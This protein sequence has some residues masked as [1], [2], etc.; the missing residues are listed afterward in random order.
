MAR[1]WNV[2]SWFATTVLALG[3]CS[4]DGSSPDPLPG[5]PYLAIVARLDV[6]D[7]VSAGAR[8][9]FH[10]EELSGTLGIDTVFQV[11]PQDTIILSVPPATYRVQMDGLPSNCI[12]RYG[13]EQLLLVPEGSNTTL[14]RYYV[15]CR[16]PLVVQVYT[17]GAA[18][19]DRYYVRATGDSI[20]ERLLLAA[21]NDTLVLDSIPGGAEIQLE[22]GALSP[23]C[24]ITTDGRATQRVTV[25]PAG[26]TIVTFRVRCSEE[27]RRPRISAFVS[28]AVDGG[29]VL[30]FRAADPDRDIERYTFDL[31]DCQGRSVLPNGARLR[32]GLSSGRTAR[33]DSVIVVGA[34]ELPLTAAEQAGRCAELRV[35]D[36]SGNTSEWT[37]VTASG[38]GSPP[39]LVSSGVGFRTDAIELS[40]TFS[41]RD[42]DFAGLFPFARLLDGTLAV[43]DGVPDLGTF[44]AAGYLQP[45]LPLVPLGNGRPPLQS[46]ERFIVHALDWRGNAIRREVPLF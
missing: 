32:R 27:A 11:A 15:I 23:N 28:G 14:A 1:R 13:P 35:E 42:G 43:P 29:R 5:P 25:N 26:A 6:A 8:Y 37:R 2:V 19:D 18:R 40:V 46:Y 9:T 20:G 16:T 21:A 7:G 12:S 39:V 30:A 3:A 44:N 41:D 33:A 22:L 36:E 4:E 24:V 38:G 34:F 31:T 10:V 45:P 17:D